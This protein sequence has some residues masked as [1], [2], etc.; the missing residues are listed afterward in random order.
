LVTPFVP[1]VSVVV[2]WCFEDEASPFTDS[3]LQ[4]AIAGARLVVPV[5]WHHELANAL[6]FGIRKARITE[7]RIS[8]FL[9]QLSKFS[10]TLD[11]ESWDQAIHMTRFLALQHGLTVYD[12]A[13]LE[14]ALRRRLPLATLDTQLAKAAQAAGATLLQP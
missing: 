11:P 14:L 7:Q 4:G 2:P 13:Y 3:L 8:S 5:L 9:I 1:D 10:L 6:L 12:A